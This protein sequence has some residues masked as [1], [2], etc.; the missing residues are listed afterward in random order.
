MDEKGRKKDIYQHK[1]NV[2]EDR[3]APD[4]LINIPPDE[5][6]GIEEITYEMDGMI[7]NPSSA[8]NN[9]DNPNQFI[10][11][12]LLQ[13]LEANTP[14]TSK[15]INIQQDYLK[16]NLK[17]DLESDTPQMVAS[18]PIGS[19]TIQEKRDIIAKMIQNQGSQSPNAI[20]SDLYL[21]KSKS[22][23][24]KYNS[25]RQPNNASPIYSYFNTSQKILSEHFYQNEDARERVN[26]MKK[27][28]Y[29]K[30]SLGSNIEQK[31]EGSNPNNPLMNMNFNFFNQ[32]VNNLLNSPNKSNSPLIHQQDNKRDNT[33]KDQKYIDLK[34]NYDL[35]QN[36]YYNQESDEDEESPQ[37]TPLN[38][39]KQSNNK[40]LLNYP[41][42][43]PNY[44]ANINKQF[45][46]PDDF[47]Q[48]FLM[49]Q[50]Y[51]NED[52]IFEKF[53]KRGWECEKCSNFNFESK[54]NS[55][56][57]FNSSSKV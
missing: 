32:N 54:T 2:E 17:E 19:D 20:K 15:V 51:N 34:T 57:T 28:T 46:F 6:N 25:N 33:N 47:N 43:S 24:F 40:G 5:E 21:D 42:T 45:P 31:N 9:I 56:K 11:Q 16:I 36:Q 35:M 48:E 29:D 55:I 52:Y 30:I 4:L 53:G 27:Q 22:Q 3:N 44:N 41:E 39:N 13:K 12:S 23:Q 50:K 7:I 8:K 18:T 37:Y 38:M 26:F 49:T 14:M 10:S 1:N